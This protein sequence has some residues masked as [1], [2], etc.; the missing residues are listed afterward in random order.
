MT[1]QKCYYQIKKPV[2]TSKKCWEFIMNYQDVKNTNSWAWCIHLKQK[3]TNTTNENK[4]VNYLDKITK[5]KSQHHLLGGAILFAKAKPSTRLHHRLLF[6]HT[7][8]PIK[9]IPR[10]T[11]ASSSLSMPLWT[12]K[13]TVMGSLYADKQKGCSI[14]SLLYVKTCLTAGYHYFWNVF[15]PTKFPDRR[16]LGGESPLTIHGKYQ[17][18]N[19]RHLS[20]NKQ[21]SPTA[22]VW[23]SGNVI[24][25][26]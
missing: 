23:W 19:K 6:P 12:W 5:L 17:H 25:M 9:A 3:R 21:N 7:P 24:T 15:F 14:F 11:P 18:K 20:H 10:V 4:L 26:K 16:C 22:V 8:M 1:K 2:K 13:W